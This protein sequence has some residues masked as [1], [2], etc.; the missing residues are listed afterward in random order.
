[1]KIIFV[2]AICLSVCFL[3]SVAFGCAYTVRDV[4]FVDIGSVPYCLYFQ[5]D[6]PESLKSSLNQISYAVFMD[7]NVEVKTINVGQGK[8]QPDRLVDNPAISYP[9]AILVSPDGHS[10]ALKI[11]DPNKPFKETAWSALEDVVTS[12]K[13]EEI[14]SSAVKA[15]CAVLLICGKESAEKNLDAEK[16][17]KDA[18]AELSRIMTQMPKSIEEPPRLVSIPPELFS[19]ER[20]LLWSLGLN[21]KDLNEPCVAV[22]YGRGRRLGS[23]LKGDQITV[24]GVFNVLSVIGESCECGLS[25]E[26]I[27][28][29]MIPL[30]WD[31]KTQSDLAKRLGFDPENPAVKTEISQI[32]ATDTFSVGGSQQGSNFANYSEEAVK[33]EGGSTSNR[34]SPAE[35]H[36]LTSAQPQTG[37][38]P[39]KQ[40]ET[41]VETRDSR[42]KSPA[43]PLVKERDYRESPQNEADHSGSMQNERNKLPEAKPQPVSDNIIIPTGHPYIKMLSVISG[44]VLLIISGGV[45]VLLLR[46]RRRSL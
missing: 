29:T 7:S 5:G 9:T 12:P 16:A 20:I 25:K 46:V 38:L 44:M 21:E 40:E 26:W 30:R 11:S 24:N 18:I 19:Q 36:K 17:V 14:L 34:I 8:P 33:L 10:L 23:L 4:G 45:F 2:L 41:P 27:L 1:M 37:L 3:P 43:P 28:G 15:Y 32:L 39:L 13:R 42:Q 22:L 6:T 35:L 31:R